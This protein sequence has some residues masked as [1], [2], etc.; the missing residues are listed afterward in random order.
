MKILSKTSGKLVELSVLLVLILL[1]KGC[2]EAEK[3]TSSTRTG[4]V[5]LWHTFSNEEAATL[6]VVLKKF[7]EKFP[8][9]KVSVESVPFF[10][11]RNKFEQAVKNNIAPDIFRSDRFWT[12]KFAKN[13]IIEPL[14]QIFKNQ[15][16][17]LLGTAKTLV[18]Y[19]Q[20]VWGIPHSMDCLALLYN[21]R[22]FAEKSLSPPGDFDTFRETAKVLTRADSG[23]YGFF[24]NPSGWWFETM[25]FAFGGKYFDQNGH[26]AIRS[27]QTLKALHFLIDLKETSKVMPPVNLR[28]N[29]Y[30]LMTQSFKSGQVSMI[31]DGPWAIKDLLNSVAFRD[32]TNL[33]VAKIPSGPQGCFSPVG[34][35]SFVISKGSRN[36][37]DA[38][39]LINFLCEPENMKLFTQ[40]NYMIPTKKTQLNDSE[41]KK[42]P[43]L[44][45]FITQIHSTSIPDNSPDRNKFYTVFEDYLHKCLN[46]EI[47]P[48]DA[49]KDIENAYKN[50][51]E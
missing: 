40:N 51:P 1:F 4:K 39:E 45:Q 42:N 27:E 37:K 13:G 26:L 20:Q 38:A 34:C 14:D 3:G 49:M 6:D 21:K 9:I 32:P 33:G 19:N 31:F 5:L 50:K 24:M 47:T 25:I 28:N 12:M 8:K 2:G 16:P 17:E 48:Q 11:A 41:I 15:I 46:G 43:F 36:I 44:S 23:R 29:A 10:Q 18:T 30:N 22:H 7:S 35:Q